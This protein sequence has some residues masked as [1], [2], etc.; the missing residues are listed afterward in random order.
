MF[1]ICLIDIS[2]MPHASSMYLI[3]IRNFVFFQLNDLNDL[4]LLLT[5]LISN[6][7]ILGK[8]SKTKTKTKSSPEFKL[9]SILLRLYPMGHVALTDK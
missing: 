3:R 9:S 7:S 5:R 2:S 8:C 1:Y 6:N 4:L